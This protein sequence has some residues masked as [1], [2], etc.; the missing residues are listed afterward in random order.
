MSILYFKD[1]LIFYILY[2]FS[3][4]PFLIYTF[5]HLLMK[6][7]KEKYKNIIKASYETP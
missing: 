5:S 7:L 2:L 4:T 3:F 6:K 1:I